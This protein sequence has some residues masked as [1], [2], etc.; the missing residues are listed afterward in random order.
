M[1]VVPGMKHSWYIFISSNGNQLRRDY[2]GCFMLKLCDGSRMN[3]NTQ[4]RKYL[5]R[6]RYDSVIDPKVIQQWKYCMKLYVL[7]LRN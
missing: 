7:Q 3:R 2:Y 5:Y 1:V 6:L 4:F